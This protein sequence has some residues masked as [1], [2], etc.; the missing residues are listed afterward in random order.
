[1]FRDT[2]E[3]LRALRRNPEGERVVEP[4]GKKRVMAVLGGLFYDASHGFPIPLAGVSW[5][6]FD[7]HK[8]GL[9]LSAFFAGPIFIANLS[10]QVNKNFRWGVDLSLIALPF[11]Y[12]D[13]SGNQEVTAQRVRSFQQYVGGLVNYQATAG[14]DFSLQAQLLYNLYR[15]TNGTDPAYRLPASGFTLDTYGEAKYVH[16]SFTALGTLE[17]GT[18]LGWR[19]F[20]YAND[21]AV[22]F[23]DWTRYSLE[24]SQHVFVGKLTRAG[25]SAGYFGGDRLDRF[26]QY[27]PGFLTRPTMHGIPSGVDSFDQVATLSGNYGFNVADLAKLEGFYTH[28]W[29]KNRLEGTGVRQF[30][31]LDASIGIAGPFGTFMQGSVSFAIRGNLERYASRWGTYL[32]FLKPLKK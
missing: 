10:R 24:L 9:Q 20:G 2:E 3:G 16:K 7:W 5:V 14:L 12:Y 13:Y 17:N 22:T 28:A 4:V 18:R 1:M 11:T 26:S 8:T 31:G 19:A 32:V 29:T 23:S 30:D 6:D 27:S 21:P 15:A 25:V